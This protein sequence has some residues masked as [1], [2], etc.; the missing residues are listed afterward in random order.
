LNLLEKLSSFIILLSVFIGIYV[1]QFEAIRT[2]ADRFILPL[3]VVML[4]ITFLQTPHEKITN[5]FRNRKFTYTSILINFIWTP[6][7]AGLL[8]LLLLNDHPAL[9]IGF[10][11][12]MVTPCTDWYLIF[13]NLAKGN[14]AL[15]TAILP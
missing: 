15:S 10:L 5:A 12:L 14:T 3:L 7:I 1:G 11:M 4:F 9:Y 8:A 2:N 6:I 13:T